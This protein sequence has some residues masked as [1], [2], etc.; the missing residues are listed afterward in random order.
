MLLAPM[1]KILLQQYRHLADM[2]TDF[3][4]V[5]FQGLKRTFGNAAAIPTSDID[6]L[7]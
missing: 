1:L 4:D 6:P 3:G 5:R 2:T 7:L